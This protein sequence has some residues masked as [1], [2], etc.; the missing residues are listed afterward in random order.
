M[1]MERQILGGKVYRMKQE[2]F[3]QVNSLVGTPARTE[4]RTG[5]EKTASSGDEFDLVAFG[6]EDD[7][8][9]VDIAGFSGLNN[10][11]DASRRQFACFLVN[12]LTTAEAKSQV[13]EANCPVVLAAKDSFGM[14]HDLHPRA[15]FETQEIALKTG[16][17]IVVFCI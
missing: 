1:H 13:G 9:V 5:G 4:G 11:R 6:V 17:L 14:A 3:G 15:A 10:D 16:S 8:F 2:T 12:S 7:A